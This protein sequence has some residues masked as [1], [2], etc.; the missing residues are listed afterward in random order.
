MFCRNTHIFILVN[1]GYFKSSG[2]ILPG[3][4]PPKWC[5]VSTVNIICR[6]MYGNEVWSIG[7]NLLSNAMIS[8]PIHVMESTQ[9]N[10]IPCVQMVM[11]SSSSLCR[12]SAQSLQSFTTA[13]KPAQCQRRTLRGG[14]QKGIL[15][16]KL[17]LLFCMQI[18]CKTH[19]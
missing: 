13:T 14:S 8:N 1:N 6:R 18:S 19:S 11:L 3:L 9:D 12:N 4:L 2:L 16:N 10:K 5:R 17:P 7:M 15:A